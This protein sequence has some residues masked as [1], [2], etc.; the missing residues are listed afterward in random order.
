M[1][2][3]S[4]ALCGLLLLLTAVPGV[5][6]DLDASRLAAENSTVECDRALAAAQD[7]QAA[8]GTGTIAM[9][10]GVPISATELRQR[11]LWHVALARDEDRSQSSR[12]RAMI[13]QTLRREAM[14]RIA[15]QRADIILPAPEVD[16]Q[17]DEFLSAQGLTRHELQMSLERTGV[18]FGTLRSIV[19]ANMLR[20]RL[21]HTGLP[22]LDVPPWNC[23]KVQ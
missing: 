22:A 6:A 4:I 18:Q 11:I 17:I 9:V 5:S 1:Q 23:L 14:D 16:A 12:A 2:G 21:T 3:R 13:L 8:I 10:E 7:I 20:A 15:A 19:A